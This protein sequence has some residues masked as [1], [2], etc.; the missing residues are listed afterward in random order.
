[1]SFVISC[2]SRFFRKALVTS[3]AAHLQKSWGWVE[4]FKVHRLPSVV[5]SHGSM[6]QRKLISK[7]GW[8]FYGSPRN[9]RH[10]PTLALR[11]NGVMLS[12][13]LSLFRREMNER[14]ELLTSYAFPITCRW[15]PKLPDILPRV[16]RRRAHQQHAIK[17]DRAVDGIEVRSVHPCSPSLHDATLFARGCGDL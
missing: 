5:L 13:D 10:E 3:Q 2:F 17:L 12:A 14:N 4:I 7:A 16:V 8:C 6:S 15:L 9:R 11:N 1:M